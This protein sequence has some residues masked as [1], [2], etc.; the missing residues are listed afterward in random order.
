MLLFSATIVVAQT[1][2]ATKTAAKGNAKA[3]KGNTK[4]VLAADID[5]SV[6]ING[7]SKLY[8]VKAY[9]PMDVTI[10]I[11][12]NLIEATSADKKSTFSSQV[13]GKPGEKTVVEISFFDHSKFLEYVQAGKVSMVEEAIRK[14][15]GLVTNQDGDLITSPLRIAIESSQ[16]EIVTLLMDKGA[17]F[18]KPVNIYPLHLSVKFASSTKTAKDKPAPDIQLMEY[19]LSKGCTINDKDES[20][21]TPLHCAA[22]S[23]KLEVVEKLINM[24]ADVNAKNEYGETPLKIAEDKGLISIIKLLQANGAKAQ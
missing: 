18:L 13:V 14:N 2:K 11:G 16:P 5:C 8:N 19:F 1:A 20:G 21:N 3:P 17:S 6:K 7:S 22:K 10:K 12:D 23:G 4:G 24:G 9:T 15:P